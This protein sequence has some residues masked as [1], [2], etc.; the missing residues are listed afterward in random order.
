MMT[1]MM[2]SLVV[3]REPLSFANL[4]VESQVLLCAWLFP[5]I[6]VWFAAAFPISA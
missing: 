4:D 3:E 1:R 5:V 2:Q 6:A